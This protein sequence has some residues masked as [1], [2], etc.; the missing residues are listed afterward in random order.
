M[1]KIALEPNA[2][3]TGTFSIASPATNTNR[4]LTL[5]D[6][7]G[8]VLTSVSAIPAAQITGLSSGGITLLGTLATTSGTSVTLSGLDLTGYTRLQI[9]V[10]G[11]SGSTSPS[12]LLLNSKPFTYATIVNA[13][14]T[15]S[16]GGII[17]LASGIFF[18]SSSILATGSGD[19]GFGWGGD[20]GLTTSSTSITFTISAGNFDAG[21]IK[22]YGV[23]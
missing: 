17:D 15:C 23:A 8:T 3:G 4:T 22:I 7:T 21:S 12:T 14:T 13:A 20:S 16:G 1:S 9:I 10:S 11:I 2:A 18:A 6:E 19:F 5:P